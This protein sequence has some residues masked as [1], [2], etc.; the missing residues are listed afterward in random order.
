MREDLLSF[1]L[2]E[3][4]QK[5]IEL[6][7]KPFRAK[8][9]ADWLG[10]AR[11]FEEMKNLPES[12]VQ[13]L[14]ASFDEGL[15]HMEMR[16][17][18]QDGTQKYL[19]RYADGSLVESVLMKYH[20]G[21]TIC[22]STQ[23]GCRMGC[24]F[25]ASGQHG[26]MRNL[27]AGEMLGQVLMVNR[28]LGEGGRNITNMVLMG[29]GEPMDNYDQVV[30]FLKNVNSPT[31]LGV[32]YRNIS[33]STCGLPEKIRQFAQENLPVTLCLSL[34][35]SS[36][37]QRKKVM[38]VAKRYTIQQV[39]DAVR[40][41]YAVSGR[42]VII[43]YALMKGV[44]DSAEDVNR[45]RGLLHGLLCHINVIPLN[46]VKESSLKAPSKKEAY[47]FAE[48]LEQV[49]LSATVRRSLGVDIN[50]AC[51]QLRNQYQRDGSETLPA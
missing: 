6:G 50:G 24:A 18:S 7:E 16:L 26:L 35:A 33:V 14:R 31:Y 1:T 28:D 48:K 29:S 9:I 36:D 17:V 39:M 23:V 47:V 34:H 11:R 45:L 4:K 15:P 25:C 41:Y 13:K 21:N 5:M 40:D 3:L 43:E 42:R 30:R 38:A 10:K 20:H 51:G 22:L 46:E 2:E 44:N 8:Q 27:T 49:G 19:F 12:L 37:E 32:S